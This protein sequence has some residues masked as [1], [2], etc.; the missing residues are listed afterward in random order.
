MHD[1]PVVVL[2][3]DAR[4]D[5]ERAAGRLRDAG[6]RNP[7]MH[8]RCLEDLATWRAAHPREIAFLIVHAQTCREA[9]G[10]AGGA[11]RLP[12]YPAFVVETVDNRLMASMWLSPGVAGMPPTPFDAHAVVRSLHLLG[13]RWLVV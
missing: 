6:L 5:V 1:L 8:A 11:S 4:G 9:G 13:L 12:V 7:M 3:H 10:E 2:V